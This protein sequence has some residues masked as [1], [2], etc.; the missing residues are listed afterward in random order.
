MFALLRESPGGQ[1]HHDLERHVLPAAERSAD[2]GVDD[3]DPVEVHIQ[4]VGDLLPILMGPLTGHLDGDP[5]LVVEVGDGGLR[6]EVRVFLVGDLVGGFDHHGGLGPAVVHRALADP[7]GVVVVGLGPVLGVDERGAGVEGGVDVGQDRQ[8]LPFDLDGGCS[9]LRRLGCFRDDDGEMV[10]L[11]A[12]H[13][14]GHIRRAGVLGRDHHRLIEQG[15][16]VFV[17]RDVG[18]GQHHDHAVGGPSGRHVERQQTGVRLVGED[19]L[20]PEGIG[21]NPV[22]RILGLTGDLAVAVDSETGCLLRSSRTVLP[23]SD[24][25]GGNRHG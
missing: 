9:G 11:P 6:L 25:G 5:V 19:D 13:V 16:A 23:R 14:A 8:R 12:G 20:G 18:A 24:T 1:R 21:G 22:G 15:Q 17:D 4:C 2:G 3:P 10:G 7:V